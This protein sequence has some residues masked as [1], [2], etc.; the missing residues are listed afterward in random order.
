M[1]LVGWGVRALAAAVIV[2]A[3]CGVQPSGAGVT[4]CRRGKERV[5][6]QNPYAQ[7]VGTS[8]SDREGTEYFDVFACLKT[9][10]RRFAL[11]EDP[12]LEPSVHR[13]TLHGRYVAFESSWSYEEEEAREVSVLNISSG[14]NHLLDSTGCYSCEDFSSLVLKPNGSTAW[15]VNTGD[16]EFD[17][18]TI[19]VRSCP[20]QTCLRSPSQRPRVLDPGPRVTPGSLRLAG[21]RVSWRSRGHWRAAR[22]R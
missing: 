17:E 12:D 21:S 10:G 20:R 7:V 4:G 6:T 14:A 5:L 19:E 16:D 3:M 18:G 8:L 11:A 13:F 22:L 1:A 9:T 15:I 2:A